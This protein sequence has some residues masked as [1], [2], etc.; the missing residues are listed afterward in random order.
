MPF[1]D[2]AAVLEAMAT[3]IEL[4]ADRDFSTVV[5]MLGILAM[6]TVFDVFCSS[7]VCSCFSVW[8]SSFLDHFPPVAGGNVS[9]FWL[10][11]TVFF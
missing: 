7:F 11:L 2:N 1:P 3:P 9:L 5:M 6:V 8:L 10:F 4:F